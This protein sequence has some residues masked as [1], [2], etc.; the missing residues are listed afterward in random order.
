MRLFYTQNTH[1]KSHYVMQRTWPQKACSILEK[2]Y[3]TLITLR[4]SPD[5]A[6]LQS[7]ISCCCCNKLPECM[8]WKQHTFMFLQ[9]WR[10]EVQNQSHW[11]KFMVLGALP[12]FWR[13]WEEISFSL[14]PASKDCLHFLSGGLFFQY[15][16]YSKFANIVISPSWTPALLLPSV[17]LVGLLW[18]HWAPPDNPG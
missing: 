11:A 13:F 2:A 15:L 5:A 18:L 14:F 10:S 16:H 4:Q 3:L 17:P 7:I 6:W 12:S 1:D 9:L 8:G